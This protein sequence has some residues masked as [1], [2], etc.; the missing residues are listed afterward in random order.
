MLKVADHSE[1]DSEPK[2]VSFS[3][4]ASSCAGSAF[5]PEMPALVISR[6]MCVSFWEISATS[7]SRSSLEVTSQ[8]P[9]LGLS[10]LEWKDGREVGRGTVLC[11]LLEL[12][13]GFLLRSRELPYAVL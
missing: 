4:D 11:F 10:Q 12:G 13:S 1:K 8:G 9:A 3:F 7:F 2:S 5:G 6:S